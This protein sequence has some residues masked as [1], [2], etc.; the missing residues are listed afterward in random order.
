LDADPFVE[1]ITKPIKI[2]APHL[3]IFSV[4]HDASV[5]LVDLVKA[6]PP[7]K[8]REFFAAD[9]AGAVGE[10][11]AAAEIREVV[12]EPF[13]KIAEAADGR[14]DGVFETAQLGF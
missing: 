11:L 7:E 8:S 1:H 14:A 3:G 6:F 9:P 13:G 5:E 2:A 4:G 10:D 12:P